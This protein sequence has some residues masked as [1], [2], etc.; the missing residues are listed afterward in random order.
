MKPQHPRAAVAAVIMAAVKPVRDLQGVS[1]RRRK[2]RQAG[3]LPD[4]R[5]IK[6]TS[7]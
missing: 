5:A 4:V 1:K 7:G 2:G 3:I 6:V